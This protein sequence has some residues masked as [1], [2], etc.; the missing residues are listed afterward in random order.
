[1]AACSSSPAF[2]LVV[3]SVSFPIGLIYLKELSPIIFKEKVMYWIVV[4]PIFILNPHR[5][6]PFEGLNRLQAI[7]IDDDTSA[8]YLRHGLDFN[9]VSPDPVLAFSFQVSLD[10]LIR[11]K[12]LI[13]VWK[14]LLFTKSTPYLLKILQYSPS[15]WPWSSHGTSRCHIFNPRCSW[16]GNFHLPR[17]P[18][19]K[20]SPIPGPLWS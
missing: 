16:T 3:G 18:S 13:I 11:Y 17:F 2:F 5:V 1:M 4:V 8:I 19:G 7:S 15:C 20:V 14:Q 9:M 10:I 12:C 6:T